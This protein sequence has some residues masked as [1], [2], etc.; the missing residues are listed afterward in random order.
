MI[1]SA[2]LFLATTFAVI[3]W[4]EPKGA[5]WLA[6]CLLARAASLEAARNEYQR[7]RAI[8]RAKANV[9]NTD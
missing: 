5:R 6:Y 2:I 8:W 9:L 4:L 7:V 1:S 3:V